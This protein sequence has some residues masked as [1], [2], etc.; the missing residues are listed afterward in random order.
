M[1]Y[2]LCFLKRNFGHVYLCDKFKPGVLYRF[3]ARWGKVALTWG[4]SPFVCRLAKNGELIIDEKRLRGYRKPY[5]GW[6]WRYFVPMG[7][8]LENIKNGGAWK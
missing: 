5:W 7:F 1:M 8:P 3:R 4:E 2:I 6:R